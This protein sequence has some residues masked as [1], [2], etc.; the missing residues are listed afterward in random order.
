MTNETENPTATPPDATCSFESNTDLQQEERDLTTGDSASTSRGEGPVNTHGGDPD[1]V[2]E[3]G[4][5]TSSTAT[6]NVTPHLSDRLTTSAESDVAQDSGR[7]TPEGAT[8]QNGH[9]DA[10]QDLHRN[11][12]DTN[13]GE[14]DENE[15]DD[16]DAPEE[17]DEDG[18]SLPADGQLDPRTGKIVR[19]KI[20]ET[21]DFYVFLDQDLMTW[22]LFRFDADAIPGFHEKWGAVLNRVAVLE[23]I[24]VSSL[25][26][27]N[28]I[29]FRR[30]VGEG[31]A[32]VLYEK[33]D[34]TAMKVLD[35]AEVFVRARSA[36][37]ARGWYLGA[38]LTGL[39]IAA[40]ALLIVY[41]LQ[42][43]ITFTPR[44]KETLYAI[45]LGA[46]GAGLSL[47][48]RLGN[49]PLDPAA[50]MKLHRLEAGARFTAGMIGGLLTCLIFN[51]KLFA[52]PAA[53]PSER[54]PLLMAVCL[55]AGAS[56]RL[57][58]SMIG[59]LERIGVRVPAAQPS[60]P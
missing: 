19:L 8:D 13:D 36:E 55:V 45:S 52:L 34:T 53:D 29:A 10:G 33:N 6:E 15:E 38:A 57:V 59:S 4:A 50:G 18:L 44:F 46:I 54:L 43:R 27:D 11:E 35:Q 7:V 41:A 5:D 1:V 60:P 56:E 22:W 24:P 37:I 25:S 16:E 17:E 28:R 51:A 40:F 47:I 48:A 49:F 2:V 32:R 23:S 12:H 42:W 9:Q 30:L 31:V 20:L 39:A 3:S 26:E 14:T 21:A 58:P